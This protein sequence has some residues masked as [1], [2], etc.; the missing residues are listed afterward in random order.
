MPQAIRE[1]KRNDTVILET[2][3]PGFSLFRRGKVRDIYE[4]NGNLL[5]VATDRI[6]VFD[7]VLPTGIP[8]KGRVLTALSEFWF[9][10]LS[11][12]AQSHFITSSIDEM[13]EA[14]APFGDVLS[15]RAMLVKKAQ[16]LPVECVVRGY[17]AG[18]AFK[19]YQESGAIQD[20]KLPSGLRQSEKLPEPIFTPAT[21]ATSGHDE[22]IPVRQMIDMLGKDVSREVIDKSIAIFAEASAHALEKGIII[23]DSKFEWG[24]LEG[25]LILIDEVFTPDS[26]RFWP[27]DGYQPGRSQPSFDKQ[28]VRDYLESTGW[29]KTP[30]AP[31]LP[32]EVAEK[33][34]E[35]YLEAYRRLTGKDL[36][37]N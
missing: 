14:L 7:V 19:E 18:S 28:Y 4:L 5:F 15:G 29:D 20:V 33:T 37:R 34:S 27:L 17:L 13:G 30:P 10:K 6:S 12:I 23:A 24:I 2:S 36:L 11:H 16:P 1:V 8:Y 32:P 31:A 9:K 22:N 3:F 26:S 21:K 35:K 25:Q